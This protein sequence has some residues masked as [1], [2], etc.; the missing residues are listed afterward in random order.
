MSSAFH[1]TALE[2]I[3]KYRQILRKNLDTQARQ[4]KLSALHLDRKYS[5]LEDF[6]LY[7]II[8]DIIND[9]QTNTKKNEGNYYS[10]HGTTEFANHLQEFL[11]SYVRNDCHVMH[12]KQLTSRAILESI[13]T[14]SKESAALT[15]D[16]TIQHLV[17]CNKIIAMHGTDEQHLG[18]VNSLRD[19]TERNPSFFNAMIKNFEKNRAEIKKTS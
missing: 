11:D 13:Q 4:L 1:Q 9:I 19:H 15:S 16:E 8:K 7:D 6:E 2:L 5:K 3:T 18:Y 12:K 10:Y 14:I 17:K